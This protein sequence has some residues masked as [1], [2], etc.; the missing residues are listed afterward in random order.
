MSKQPANLARQDYA[1]TFTQPQTL[2]RVYGQ[3]SATALP[4]NYDD[5][6]GLILQTSTATAGATFS[7]SDARILAAGLG[8]KGPF[9][10]SGGAR[11]DLSDCSGVIVPDA[12]A[13]DE[14]VSKGQL[15]THI[16][17]AA[18]AH[19]ATAISYAG[20]ASL[21]ATDVE[22][23][24]DELDAEK[25]GLSLANTFTQPQPVRRPT[26]SAP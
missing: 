11:L 26:G 3:L 14:A 8:P 25:A 4:A 24:L 7:P 21:A 23:A 2:P 13:A 1:N 9:I 22:A 16:N 5:Q 18:G 12:D 15:D 17:E 19:A 6:Q 20:S 10:R